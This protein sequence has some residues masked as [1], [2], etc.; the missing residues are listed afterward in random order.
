MAITLHYIPLEASR[1]ER[2]FWLL[3]ELGLEYKVTAHLFKGPIAPT[4]QQVTKLG[5]VRPQLL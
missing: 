2:L 5:K 4:L 1:A 3:E